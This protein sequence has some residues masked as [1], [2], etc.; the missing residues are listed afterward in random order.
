MTPVEFRLEVT[1][2]HMRQLDE[3]R[4]DLIAAWHGASLSVAAMVGKLPSM[5]TVLQRFER[6]TQPRPKHLAMAHMHMLSE[7]L[8][9]GL[10]PIS[11]EGKAAMDRLRASYA[12]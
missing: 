10:R 12:Q 6:A 3:Y 4:R 9:I 1:A 11:P 2:A 8:G 7:H 5:A